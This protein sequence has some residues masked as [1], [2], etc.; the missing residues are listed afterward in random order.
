MKIK[1][2]EDKIINKLLS[3]SLSVV[4][5]RLSDWLYIDNN[6]I[7]PFPIIIVCLSP[8]YRPLVFQSEECYDMLH[9]IVDRLEDPKQVSPLEPVS[10]NE[11]KYIIKDVINVLCFNRPKVLYKY[12]ES[13]KKIFGD[14]L[15]SAL[16][17]F[18][19]WDGK[20]PTDKLVKALGLEPSP[21][22]ASSAIIDFISLSK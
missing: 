10:Y 7:I 1:G 18:G 17:Y 3:N 2:V 19:F 13:E 4:R 22:Q 11:R 21:Y 20:R 12:S 15:P 9:W 5:K 6:G 16:E 14:S 8:F